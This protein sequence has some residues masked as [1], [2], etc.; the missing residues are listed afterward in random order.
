M[1]V[2]PGYK[3]INYGVILIIAHTEKC[4]VLLSRIQTTIWGLVIYFEDYG[5][6]FAQCNF[7]KVYFL[8]DSRS[9][10]LEHSPTLFLQNKN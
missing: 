9:T 7:F 5:F 3:I 10:R 2:I 6:L 8:Q 1:S 4:L